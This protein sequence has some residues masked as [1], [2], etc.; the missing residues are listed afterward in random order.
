M[1]RQRQNRL[2]HVQVMHPLR[3]DRREG[4]RQK[5]GLLLI[6]ALEADP[7][8]R[9]QHR[10]QQRPR[11]GRRH[12][13]GAGQVGGALQARIPVA[14]LAVPVRHRHVLPSGFCLAVYTHSGVLGFQDTYL[15]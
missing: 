4:L 5:I 1:F 10:F 13:L 7:V 15:S 12:Q 9:L 6:V 8:A 3:A 2:D 14:G 11:L